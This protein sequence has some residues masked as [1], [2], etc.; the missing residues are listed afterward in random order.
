MTRFQLPHSLSEHIADG[1]VHVIGVAAAIGGVSALMTWA[2]LKV[3]AA[4]IWPL[5]FYAAGVIAT[6]SLSA[7]YNLTVHAR[8]RAILQRFDHAAIY[9]MIAGT[10]TPIAINGLGGWQGWALAITAW[11]VAAFGIFVKLAYFDGWEKAGFVLYLALG[12]VGIVA[13]WPLVETLPTSALVLLLIGGVTYTA[14]TIFYHF[15]RLPF[16]RAIWHSHVL[17]AAATHFVAV[18]IITPTN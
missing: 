6:F 17:A 5:A 4:W 8:A 9:L 2:A 7:A 14:G 13:A 11:T 16:S 10:Y 18:L 12:W 3:P 1:V 15:D